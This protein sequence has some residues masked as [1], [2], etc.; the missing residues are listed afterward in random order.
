MGGAT[1][2]GAAFAAGLIDVCNLYVVPVA[3]GG[4]KPALQTNTLLNL[5]L[6]EQRRF[7]NGTVYLGYQVAGSTPRETE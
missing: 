6:T 4:G 2:A 1:L 7:D 3:V 5:E